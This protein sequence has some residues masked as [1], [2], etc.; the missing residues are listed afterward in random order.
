MNWRGIQLSLAPECEPDED[1][2]AIEEVTDEAAELILNPSE[3]GARARQ[4]QDPKTSDYPHGL[5]VWVRADGSLGC[6]VCA[7][8]AL[9]DWIEARLTREDWQ[10]LHAEAD[11]GAKAEADDAG[12]ALMR[13]RAAG[14]A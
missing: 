13:D 10:K 7:E 1:F 6:A 8:V 14:V 4:G 9:I 12:E 11:E 2:V 3:L 5:K